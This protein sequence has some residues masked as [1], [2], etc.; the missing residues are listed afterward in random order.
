MDFAI[1]HIS[2][3]RTQTYLCVFAYKS[4]TLYF[5]CVRTRAVVFVGKCTHLFLGRNCNRNATD[6]ALFGRREVEIHKGMS[7]PLRAEAENYTVRHWRSAGE[8]G[9][10]HLE[11][12][13]PSVARAHR[14]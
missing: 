8:C 2:L 13:R 9:G 14:G 11:R 10:V 5:T 6:G 3:D 1:V 4:E 7:V 12:V